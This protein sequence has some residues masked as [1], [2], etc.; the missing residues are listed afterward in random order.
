MS[1]YEAQVN[2]TV[3][4]SALDK[5][6]QKLDS[7]TK[8]GKNVKV[9]ITADTSDL[10]KT[11]SNSF[12]NEK[13]KVGF[14]TSSAKS[15]IKSLKSDFQMV[16]NLANEISSLKVKKATL[17]LNP[18]KN[19]NQI[20]ALSTQIRHLESD[21]NILNNSI[22]KSFNTTQIGQLEN[23]AGKT[24]DKVEVLNAK[25]KDLSSTMK[26]TTSSFNQLDAQVASN[27]TLSWLQ[28]NTKAADKYGDQLKKLA[29]L[30]RNA[31]SKEE[32]QDYTKQVR[33]LQTEAQAFGETG[34]VGKIILDVHLD[35]FFNFLKSM[36]EFKR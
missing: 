6:Q 30:Q 4:D 11:V 2:V 12:K 31:T 8:N 28:N 34:K 26:M 17:E 33:A 1:Q 5:A 22:G 24:A 25:A 15:S 3:N 13:I 21:Y 23:I 7:L 32:L 16:K 18:E 10:N 36:A 29:E 19:A 27:R 20:A 14:D 35:K 9:K